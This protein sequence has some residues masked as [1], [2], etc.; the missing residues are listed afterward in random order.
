M[1]PWPKLVDK[2]QCCTPRAHN[3]TQFFLKRQQICV[4]HIENF[5]GDVSGLKAANDLG[6]DH[7]TSTPVRMGDELQLAQEK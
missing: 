3:R 6:N 2:T 5:A 4:Q 1:Q 7:A